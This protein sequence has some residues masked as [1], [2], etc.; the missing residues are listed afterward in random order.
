VDEEY[1]Y[2]FNDLRTTLTIASLFGFIAIFISCLGLLGLS[3]FMIESR[4]K[5]ISIRKVMGGSVSSIVKF[6][7]VDALKPIVVAIVLFSP[8]AWWAMNWWLQSFDYRISLE[9]WVFLFSGA[10][11]LTIA[12]ITV[13]W[14]TIGAAR[15]NPV[16]SLRAN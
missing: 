12:L 5:E 6:L 8:M 14:Q 3:T 16:K 15:E 11:I 10:I 13:T 1:Q 9:L 2:K 4:V 7:S